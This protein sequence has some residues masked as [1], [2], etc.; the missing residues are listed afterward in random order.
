[1]KKIVIWAL[2][3]AALLTGCSEDELPRASFDRF[4]VETVTAT[5]GDGEAAV[6]W[7]AQAEKPSRWTTM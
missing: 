7:T 2:S 6:S 4:Q 3:C 1:M 5:A